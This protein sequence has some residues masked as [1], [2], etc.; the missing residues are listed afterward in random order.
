MVICHVYY[1]IINAACY[2]VL[3]VSKKSYTWK[4]KLASVYSY[5]GYANSFTVIIFHKKGQLTQSCLKTHTT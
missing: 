5:F 4:V 1:T 3:I 2:F